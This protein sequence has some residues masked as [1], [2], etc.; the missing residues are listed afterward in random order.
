MKQF[1]S[2]KE[3]L[4]VFLPYCFK[5]LYETAETSLKNDKIPLK[6]D[7]PCSASM[8]QNL[9]NQWWLSSVTS[10]E[11]A[12]YGIVNGGETSEKT[13]DEI[14]RDCLLANYPK[15]L[16]FN[17]G[18]VPFGFAYVNNCKFQHPIFTERLSTLCFVS[19]LLVPP[20]SSANYLDKV[21]R[22]RLNWWKKFSGTPSNYT[23]NLD[24]TEQGQVIHIQNKFPWNRSETV[25][26]IHN[27]GSIE[28]LGSQTLIDLKAKDGR[29]LV[30]PHVIS[31]VM[32]YEAAMMTFLTEALR[33]KQSK[34]NSS[35]M[36]LNLHRFLAP[37][38]VSLTQS[39]SSSQLK[40]LSEF[41]KKDLQKFGIS[42]YQSAD[43]Q[44]SL[45]QQFHKCDEI[46]IPY[47]LVLNET[48]LKNGILGLRSRDTTLQEQ[49]HISQAV[50]L[51]KRYVTSIAE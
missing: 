47:C 11:N 7:G 44:Q 19:E 5:N 33:E 31:T 24:K 21:Q 35:R 37:Y 43:Q 3:Y 50:K 20:S 51:V 8:R 23:T 18:R 26:T 13:L 39:I 27:R 10:N 41:L 40:E 6:F 38:K 42:V 29:K 15:L 25:E 9:I 48:T 17:G 12:V 34:N 46:G 2:L 14:S 32:S 22:Q 36:V 45:E 16:E 49:S 28:H 4:N 30:I 1:N